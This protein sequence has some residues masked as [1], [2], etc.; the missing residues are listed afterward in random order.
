MPRN[1]EKYNYDPADRGRKLNVY[2]TFR[3]DVQDV[4]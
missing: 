3:K 2:K 1:N 4:F